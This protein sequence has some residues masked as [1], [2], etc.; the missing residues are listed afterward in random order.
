MRLQLDALHQVLRVVHGLGQRHVE[1]RPRRLI[2]PP[3]GE[4]RIAHDPDDAE[5][6]RV[7]GIVEAEVLLERILTGLEEALHER[8]VHDGHE[9][10]RLVVGLA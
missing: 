3:A 1:H 10:G 4:L 5:R 6:V 8:L 9:P 2:Q 7:L